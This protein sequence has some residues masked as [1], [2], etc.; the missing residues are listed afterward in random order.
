MYYS[1]WPYNIRECMGQEVNFLVCPQKEAGVE[2]NR[3]VRPIITSLK[4]N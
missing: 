2:V 1:V 4:F 3:P